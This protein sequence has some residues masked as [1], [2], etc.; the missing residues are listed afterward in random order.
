MKKEIF[1]LVTALFLSCNSGSHQYEQSVKDSIEDEVMTT[2]MRV[3]ISFFDFFEKFMWD[4]EFQI[5]IVRFPIQEFGNT[6]VTLEDWEHL[7]FYT[8]ESYIPG[9]SSDTLRLMDK[10]VEG[11]SIILFRFDH[12][13]SSADKFTFR[14]IDGNWH[15]LSV[16][17]ISN[18][19]V[20]DY[21]FVDHIIRFSND[22]IFQV[23]H[24]V[25][26]LSMSFADSGNDYE[27]AKER[28]EVEDWKFWKLIDDIDGLM[29]LSNIQTTSRFR[30][31]SFRGVENGIWSKYTFE[32]IDEKWMLIRLEDYST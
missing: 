10:D 21:E 8:E 23:D 11:E 29:I 5:S 24:I 7:P 28:I 31:I 17:R 14:K 15:L 12:K 4:K 32:K 26:P 1:I 9:L 6:I 30:N 22:S 19:E 18:E 20:P 27:T 2:E 16:D 25:F 13:N 3:D